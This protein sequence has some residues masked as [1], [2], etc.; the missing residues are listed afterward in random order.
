M[1]SLAPVRLKLQV[2]PQF[3]VLQVASRC[4]RGVRDEGPRIC[5]SRR[6]FVH[7]LVRLRR[8]SLACACVPFTRGHDSATNPY[9]VALLTCHRNIIATKV[10]VVCALPSDR[11]L[12]LPSSDEPRFRLTGTRTCSTGH[13][14]PP[15]GVADD[16]VFCRSSRSRRDAG[17]L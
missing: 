13:D 14:A 16:F 12:Y 7:V 10:R 5:R 2:K 6:V 1:T 4:E 8:V 3:C 15:E 9:N 11:L 17:V